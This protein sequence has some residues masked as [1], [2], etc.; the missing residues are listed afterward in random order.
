ML[1]VRKART[2]RVTVTATANKPDVKSDQE[3]RATR[4]TDMPDS[5]CQTAH[6]LSTAKPTGHP[7]NDK[8]LPNTRVC[9]RR[10]LDGN[11]LAKLSSPLHDRPGGPSSGFAPAIV[12]EHHVVSIPKGP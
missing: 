5:T 10:N 8:K 3:A 7:Q 1:V 11:K 2:T 4:N 9:S 6:S 12:D